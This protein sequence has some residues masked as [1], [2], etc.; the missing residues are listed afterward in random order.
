MLAAMS[1]HDAVGV[2]DSTGHEEEVCSL[3]LEPAL[4]FACGR[5]PTGKI[6]IL[7]CGHT[8]HERYTGWDERGARWEGGGGGGALMVGAPGRAM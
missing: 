6:T 1:V 2:G 8:L 3:C 4:D 5:E 7:S